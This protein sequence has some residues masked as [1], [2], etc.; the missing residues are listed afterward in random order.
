MLKGP[1]SQLRLLIQDSCGTGFAAWFIL[2]CGYRGDARRFIQME[3][4]LKT[5]KYPDFG[6][7]ADRNLINS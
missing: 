7:Y 4:L 5:C 1:D 3:R 2:G 6:E